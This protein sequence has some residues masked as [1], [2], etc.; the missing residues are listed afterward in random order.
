MLKVLLAK[1]LSKRLGKAAGGGLFAILA[2]IG[3]VT[4]IGA[5]RP[6]VDKAAEYAAQAVTIYCQLP[7]IDRETFGAKVD[8]QLHGAAFT[9]RVTVQCPPP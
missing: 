5:L 7:E 2:A 3:G 6:A 4:S 1:L 9:A 8:A